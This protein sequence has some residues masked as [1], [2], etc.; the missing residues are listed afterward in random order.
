[1]GKYIEPQDAFRFCPLCGDHGLSKVMANAI[2]CNSCGFEYFFNASG[3]VIVFV[4]YQKKLLITVRGV[5]HQKGTLDLPGGF[6]FPGETAEQAA[7]REV[8]EETGLDVFN[9]KLTF[10]KA[11]VYPYSGILIHTVDS[12]FL[13]ECKDDFNLFPNDDV[14]QCYFENIESIDSEMFGLKSV[15]ESVYWF[16]CNASNLL[17][18]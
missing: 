12:V 5:N 17:N 9:L 4:L 6:I 2:K 14:A 1:M 8:K 7:I 3:A 11:N 16:K 15:K 10:T 18:E 13:A